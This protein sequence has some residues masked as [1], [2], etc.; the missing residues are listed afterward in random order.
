MTTNAIEVFDCGSMFMGH[1]ARIDWALMRAK[2]R[3]AF[4][5]AMQA[6]VDDVTLFT[7]H[8]GDVWSVTQGGAVP[9]TVGIISG[10]DRELSPAS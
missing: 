5:E 9:Y 1:E 3:R 2:V 8:N 6:D 7:D 4:N 10:W